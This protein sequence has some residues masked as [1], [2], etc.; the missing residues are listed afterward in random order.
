ML[1]IVKRITIRNND[2]HFTV[3]CVDC[4]VGIVDGGRGT[5]DHVG[6]DGDVGQGAKLAR[7]EPPGEGRRTGGQARLV[8]I[9]V[10]D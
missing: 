8:G 4:V 6:G 9:G 10:N 1:Y 2:K 7:A 5:A 3:G